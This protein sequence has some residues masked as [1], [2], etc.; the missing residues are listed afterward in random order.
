MDGRVARTGQMRNCYK[1]LVERAED[2]EIRR[3]TQAQ[4]E[5]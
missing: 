5:G 1:R 2:K 4:M 3:I